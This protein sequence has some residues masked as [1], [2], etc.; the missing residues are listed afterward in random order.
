M[1][2]H[3]KLKVLGIIA[4]SSLF[5]TSCIKDEAPDV[6]ADILKFEFKELGISITPKID[7]PRM[8]I[9]I[10]DNNVQIS[11]LTPTITTSSHATVSPASGVAQNFSDTVYYTVTSENKAWK[12]VYKVIAKRLIPMKYDF[13]DWTMIQTGSWE[14]PALSETSWSSANS[15][16][17]VAKV[18]KVEEYPT[19][20]TDDARSGNYAAMLR[21]Q[22]GGNYYGNLVPIFSGSLFR[23]KFGP[24]NLANFAKSVKFGQPHEKERGKPIRFKGYYKYKAGDIF[25]DEKDNVIVG[26]VDEFSIYAVMYK[27]TKDAG[28]NEYLDGTNVLSSKNIIAKVELTDRDEKAEYTP[29]DLEFEYSEAPDYTAYDYKLAVVFASS[30]DGDYYRGAVGSTLIVDDVEIICEEYND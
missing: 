2:K 15:G 11:N 1:I 8:V 28:A 17:A 27:V 13:E 7:D 5:F 10:L 21:T 12:R 16:I 6:E 18:G 26:K 19:H 23:G 9:E 20:S 4:L 3:M 30:K 24:L 22:R 14:Y 29:F 25:Y